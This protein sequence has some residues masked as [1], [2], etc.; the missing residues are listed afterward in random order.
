MFE[1]SV[2]KRKEY[3]A[4][5]HLMLIDD[6]ISKKTISVNDIY[7]ERCTDREFHE[8]PKK[9]YK[10]L[11]SERGYKE[12]VAFA[13]KEGTLLPLNCPSA[14]QRLPT[15]DEGPRISLK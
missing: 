3:I 7:A 2:A 6:V 14:N 4:K 9:L 13:V 15:L 12:E 1:W 5:F 11:V 8:L 10:I